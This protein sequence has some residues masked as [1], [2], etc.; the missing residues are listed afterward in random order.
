[1][2]I[3]CLFDGNCQGTAT[4]NNTVVRSV[5]LENGKVER[6]VHWECDAKEKHK[7]HAPIPHFE[8]KISCDCAQ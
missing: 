5:T 7:F 8:P 2:G 1:M 3:K 6:W 4:S